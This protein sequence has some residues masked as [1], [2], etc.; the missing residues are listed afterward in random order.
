MEWVGANFH[1][2]GGVCVLEERF[3]MLMAVL[4]VSGDANMR[5]H[6]QTESPVLAHSDSAASSHTS[7]SVSLGVATTLFVVLLLALAVLVFRRQRQQR[8][9]ARGAS[10]LTLATAD[11]VNALS[12]GVGSGGGGGVSWNMNH[13]GTL[14]Q[15]SLSHED[16]MSPPLYSRTDEMIAE[17]ASGGAEAGEVPT[18]SPLN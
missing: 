12:N 7:L 3:N 6:S 17:L 16:V 4:T 1:D 11:H 13:V 8:R 18:K 2:R 5:G 14:P 10:S 15:Y 9:A